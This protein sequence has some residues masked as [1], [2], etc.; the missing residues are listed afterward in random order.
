MPFLLFSLL[1]LASAASGPSG[2]DQGALLTLRVTTPTALPAGDQVFVAGNFQGWQPGGQEYGLTRVDDTR[3]EI[4]LTVPAGRPLEFKF[5]RGSWQT[6]EKGNRGQE[7]GN[8]RFTPAAGEQELDLRVAAWADQAGD[9]DAPGRPHTLTGNVQTITVPDFLDGRRVWVYLPPGYEDAGDRRYPV[10]YMLDGQNVFDDA[11]S[12]VGEWHVDETLERLIP[13]GEVAPLLVVAVDNG[14]DS[15]IDEYTPWPDRQQR[16]GS[17]GQAAAHMAAIIGTLKPY[18]DAHYRTLPGPDHTGLAGSSLGGIMSLY[19][20]L[21]HGEIFGRI[22]AF[23]PSLWWDDGHLTRAI[24]QG[25]RPACRL[26]TDMGGLESFHFEDEDGNGTDDSLDRLREL[27]AVLKKL[28]F[29]EGK[30]LMVV[31]DPGA[32]HNEGAWARRFPGA[33]IFLFPGPG[34]RR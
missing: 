7:I 16:G 25:P 13:A 32:V 20:A 31:E 12:F 17:G 2:S 14:G 24:A 11:T 22:G 27:K 4:T 5:T 23:S 19:A 34:E 6:V 9:G 10:L 26:Y 21:Q 29:Q 30:D 8:R 3:W 1:I 15:R 33:V 28:G 18:V